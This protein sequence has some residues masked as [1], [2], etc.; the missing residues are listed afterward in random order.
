M[1]MQ[2]VEEDR[3]FAILRE[4]GIGIL[5]EHGV[6]LQRSIVAA[7][8]EERSACAKLVSDVAVSAAIQARGVQVEKGDDTKV[9][10]PGVQEAGAGVAGE[11]KV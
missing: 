3:A 1:D 9:V 7:I 2:T 11:G 6:K 10:V 4:A 5:S 8:R